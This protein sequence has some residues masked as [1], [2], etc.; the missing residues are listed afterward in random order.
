MCQRYFLNVIWILIYQYYKDIFCMLWIS[1]N[2]SIWCVANISRMSLCATRM[3]FLLYVINVHCLNVFTNFVNSYCFFRLAR[4]CTCHQRCY[5]G[6]LILLW[7]L[8]FCQTYIQWHWFY[9][10]YFTQQPRQS[11]TVSLI[12][13]SLYNFNFLRAL[14]CFNIFYYNFIT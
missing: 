2:M 6:L 9:G 14:W 11:L 1:S 3:F 7:M 13:Y 12:L 4:N 10:K 5:Q 8:L